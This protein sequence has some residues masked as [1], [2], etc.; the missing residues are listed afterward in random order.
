M[1]AMM[2]CQERTVG[3]FVKLLKGAGWKIDRICRFEAP[4]PQQIICSPI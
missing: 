4:L 1:L 2:N 3:E